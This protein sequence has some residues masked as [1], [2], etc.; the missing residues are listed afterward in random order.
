MAITRRPAGQHSIRPVTSKRL[1]SFS[2]VD[3]KR[4]VDAA[5]KSGLDIG[6]V[7]IRPDG[8]IRL[9][10]VGATSGGSETVFDQWNQQL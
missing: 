3:L 8:T 6:T 5:Q 7:E 1:R 2:K 9:R 4:A 10:T